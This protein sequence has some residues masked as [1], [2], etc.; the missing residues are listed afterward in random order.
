LQERF[1]KWR[2]DSFQET[3]NKR[4][5][6]EWVRIVGL[7]NKNKWKFERLLAHLA[8]VIIGYPSDSSKLS[9]FTWPTS[10]GIHDGIAAIR[11]KVSYDFWEYFM[12]ERKHKL[13]DYNSANGT[14]IA[15]IKEMTMKARDENNLGY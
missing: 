3:I 10:A 9:A 6:L 13:S 5:L 7:E 12:S 11:A 15:L 14:K 4:V 2:A 1:N 8:N